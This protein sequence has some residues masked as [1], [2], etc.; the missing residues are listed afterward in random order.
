M[1]KTL[2]AALLVAAT[3][4]FLLV[5]GTGVAKADPGNGAI[6]IK[7][8]GA[9]GMPGADADGNIIFGGIGQVTTVVTNG[10]SVIFKCKG[11]G[12]TNLSGRGQNFDGFACGVV[13]GNGNFYLTTDTHATAS[14]SGVGTMTCKVSLS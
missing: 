8:D 1:R 6:V 4:A 5:S 12:I 14:A 10:N 7:N 13:D 9:C 11:T 2:L 3:A